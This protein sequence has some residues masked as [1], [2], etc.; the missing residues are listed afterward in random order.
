MHLY[1][2]DRY[3]RYFLAIGGVGVI[4]RFEISF[5]SGSF[6]TIIIIHDIRNMMMMV[7]QGMRFCLHVQWAVHVNDMKV[8]SNILIS[9]LFIL[10][11]QGRTG[12]NQTL[13]SSD[14][15]LHFSELWTSGWSWLRKI[16]RHYIV[17][18]R[19]GYHHY[20]NRVIA[21]S[22]CIK[23]LRWICSVSCIVHC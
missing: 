10:D 20:Q 6:R 9:D 3:K 11:R 18:A 23:L 7:Q 13:T 2:A 4:T 8:L 15:W 5:F 1:I 12:W 22:S 21:V 16:I 17:V 19:G 14:N